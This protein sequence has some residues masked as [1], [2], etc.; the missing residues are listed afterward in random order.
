M[1][2]FRLLPRQ[3]KVQR[4]NLTK[5][6]GS[7]GFKRKEQECYPLDRDVL[8]DELISLAKYFCLFVCYVDF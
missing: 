7:L 4:G 8:P 2:I 3:N 6:N 5:D 1:E